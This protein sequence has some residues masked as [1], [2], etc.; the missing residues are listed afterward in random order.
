M[1]SWPEW[2]RWL[3]VPTTIA[4]V[5]FGLEILANRVLD[6]GSAF[7]TVSILV[8]SAV[9]MCFG[10]ASAPRF[11]PGAALLVGICF[12]SY[13]YYNYVADAA[14]S[15]GSAFGSAIASWL[16]HRPFIPPPDSVYHSIWMGLL[17]G[18]PVAWGLTGWGY[19]R[20]RRAGLPSG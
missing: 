14:Y 15:F 20:R 6:H 4:V 5:P 12:L 7:L 9:F 8:A 13:A 16:T 3:V 2:V 10:I 18:V 17:G 1:D 11:K 19:F